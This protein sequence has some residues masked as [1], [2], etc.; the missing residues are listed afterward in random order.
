M[1]NL[2]ILPTRLGDTIFTTGVID[3]YKDEPSTIIASP[4]TAPLFSDLP[5]L[6][7]LIIIGKKP[8]KK[9]WLEM[10][11]MTKGTKW[12]RIVDLRGSAISYF[13]KAQKRQVW[14]QPPPKEHKVFQISQ[15]MGL[16]KSTSPTLWFSKERL[17]KTALKRPTLAVAPVAGWIG[18][19]WPIDNFIQLLTKFCADYPKAQVALFAAP[20]ERKQIEPL[21][22]ALPQNQCI[23]TVGQNL[24]DSA[25]MIK[26]SSLFIGNDSGLLHLSVAVKTPSIALFGPSNDILYGP[27]SSESPS[28]HTVLRSMPIPKKKI[29]QTPLDTR[30]YMDGLKYDDVERTV[31]EKW[32]QLG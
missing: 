25:A 27:W 12:N 16:S 8:Y 11:K 21:L 9:H 24:L 3:T 32:K 18:K 7:K 22:K 13:L 14:T 1:T 23:N 31:N 2:F 20:N 5:N 19:Q 17:S 30:C 4:I 28:P 15:V 29:I 6:E 10:W 26:S